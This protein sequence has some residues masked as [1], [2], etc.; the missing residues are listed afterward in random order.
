MGVDL[1]EIV[2]GVADKDADDH[3]FEVG[4]VEEPV[5]EEDEP[6]WGEGYQMR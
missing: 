6:G 4:G 3:A 1:E 5:E 2:E